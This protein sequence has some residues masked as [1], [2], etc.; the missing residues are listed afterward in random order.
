[1]TVIVP[2]YIYPS[3]TAWEPLYTSLAKN[4]TLKFQVVVN[5]FNNWSNGTDATPDVYYITAINTL[6]SYP[7]AVPL[8][9]VHT[10]YTFRPIAD[11][12]ADIMVCANWKK[13]ITWGS[14]FHMSG[15]FFDETVYDYNSTTL[16]YMTNITTFARTNLGAGN[17]LV[18]FNPGRVVPSEWYNLADYV[19]AYENSVARYSNNT[20]G[21]I[22]P[23]NRARS[24]FIMYGFLGSAAEQVALVN[25]IVQGGIGGLYVSTE[26]VYTAWSSL[27]TEFCRAM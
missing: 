24:L 8:C 1:A 23:A 27:W 21:W 6:H 18:V 20:I 10:E 9:Y 4:P 11:V 7:N 13:Q 12:E 15:V 16:E 19:V 5:T 14:D 3:Y 22:A 2:L 26:S 17:D 25:S